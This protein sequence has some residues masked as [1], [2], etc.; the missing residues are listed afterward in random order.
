MLEYIPI[1]ILIS[2]SSYTTVHDI[3]QLIQCSRLFYHT[4]TN[5][6]ELWYNT[7]YH[8]IHYKN[9]IIYQQRR[10]NTIQN[11]IN[12]SYNEPKQL[13]QYYTLLYNSA[14]LST[15]RCSMSVT[16][17][18]NSNDNM[19]TIEPL[20]NLMDT[21]TYNSIESYK[22]IITGDRYSGV[23]SLVDTYRNEYN[24]PSSIGMSIT[25]VALRMKL[26]FTRL[27]NTNQTI[28]LQLLDKRNTFTTATLASTL[29]DD[30]TGII[31]I[32]DLTNTHSLDNARTALDILKKQLGG[33]KYN[34]L[35]ILLVGN[36]CDIIDTRCVSFYDISQFTS[37]Y[38]INYIEVSCR[39]NINI[40][41]AFNHMLL[42]IQQKKQLIDE[43]E[44]TNRMIQA[45]SLNRWLSTRNNIESIRQQHAVTV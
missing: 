2:I 20:C 22:L 37:D 11:Q 33:S 14:R 23:T 19:N 5:N 26:C 9:N 10:L 15:R 31:Y 41:L 36:K 30:T 40:Q 32:I 24:V 42:Q 18:I 29:I 34:K 16:L 1:D 43:Y 27:H 4:L 8:H 28:Q 12:S 6:H 25:D 45:E 39:Q 35:P 38:N 21:C 44:R 7:L 17:N 3:I 13:L